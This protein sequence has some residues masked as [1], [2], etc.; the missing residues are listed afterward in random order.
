M[1]DMHDVLQ[2]LMQHRQQPDPQEIQRRRQA[3]AESRCRRRAIPNRVCQGK[4]RFLRQTH[5]RR[6]R[7]CAVRQSFGRGSLRR[8]RHRLWKHRGTLAAPARSRQL[9]VP[10]PQ[11]KLLKRVALR[12][13]LRFQG[14]IFARVISSCC[15]R[16]KLCLSALC[17]PPLRQ[18]NRRNDGARATADPSTPFCL[19]RRA[20]GRSG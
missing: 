20:S 8:L 9:L 15:N 18:K 17:A 6:P 4:S 12:H 3:V 16:I 10:R 11:L 7:R 19:L 5:H 14:S 1:G 13:A 2:Q